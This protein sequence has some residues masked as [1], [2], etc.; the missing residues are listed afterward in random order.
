MG[1]RPGGELIRKGK[2]DL[3]SRT[4]T[5]ASL[6]VSIARSRLARAGLPARKVLPLPEDAEL[7][8]CKL[9]CNTQEGDAYSMPTRCLLDAYSMP[10]RCLLDAYS[11]PTRCL[12]DAC[13]RYYALLRRLT[14]FTSALTQRAAA[15]SEPP[16]FF[17]RHYLETENPGSA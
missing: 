10:T 12:L 2:A 15:A 14:S 5:V 4:V 1:L 13:S 9:L 11:M 3:E 6:L 16:N 17:S 7:I 8:L